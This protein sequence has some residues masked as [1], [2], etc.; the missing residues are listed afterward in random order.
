MLRSYF[1]T[2][3][4]NLGKSKAYSFINVLGLSIGIASS[5]LMFFHIKDEMS[6]DH[7]FPKSDRIYRLTNQGLSEGDRHWAVVSP[8]HG[9]EIQADIPEITLTT[10]LFY[11]D[12]NVLAF[13]QPESSP[14]RFEEQGGFYSDPA[15][16]EM[17]DLEFLKGDPAEALSEVN[18]MILTESMAQRY[19][20]DKDPIGQT[21]LNESRNQPYRITGVV[22]DFDFNTH[23]KFDYLVS[24][25]TFY[26]MMISSGNQLWLEARGWAHFFTYCLLGENQTL[27]QAEAKMPDFMTHFYGGQGSTPEEIL[28]RSRLNLQ[29]ITDIHL[30]SHLEQEMG[31]NSDIAYVYIFSAIAVFLLVIA[32]VNFINIAT[33]LAFQR[34]KEVGMRKVMGA[35]RGQL[36]RQFLGEAF[37]LTGISAVLALLFFQLA[38]PVY[39]NLAGR[40]LDFA[41]ITQPANLAIFLA[42]ILS[43]SLA[44]GV[45]PAL[46]MAG[47][48]PSTSL[49][50]QHDPRSSIHLVRKGLVVFQFVISIFLI[51]STI[52]IYRQVSFFQTKDL[53]FNKD[54]LIA[55][56]L[57]GALRVNAV[58]RTETL[59]TELMGHSSISHV[60][61]ASN[62]PGERL[63]VENLRPQGTTEDQQLPSVRYLRVDEDF[64]ET[65]NMTLLQGRT[66][67]DMTRSSSA[68]I[69][70]EAAV[71]AFNLEEPVGTTATNLRG[72]T[73]EIIGVVKDFN[74]ASLHHTVEPLVLDFRPTWGGWLMIRVQG[75]R[76][77]EVIKF[78]QA[79]LGAVAPENLFLYSFV[80]DEL[81]RLYAGEMRMSDV[82]KVFSLLAVFISCLG[83]FGLSAYSAE[84]R[85]KEIGMRKVLGAS[86]SQV[87]ALLSRDFFLW[88]LAANLIAW[89][90]AYFAMLDWL[91]NFAYRTPISPLTFVLSSGLALLVALLTVSLQAAKAAS[92]DPVNSL[93]HE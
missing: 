78:L 32:A 29:P 26:R 45:Y 21:I 18:T 59:K 22:A 37:I 92:T 12:V 39:N 81:T 3:V 52:T 61:L 27:K 31:P 24:M 54:S 80:D 19:F 28:S 25:R 66:F 86:V 20:R 40:Q 58:S 49:R 5:L 7:K 48:Q 35:R 1:R 33:A 83:L 77:P 70:N 64:I 71:A 72:V 15:T 14:V 16:I 90:L 69:L 34:M 9:L 13:S 56:K 76:M 43:L 57:Y 84:L 53:G 23:L 93:R 85:T 89:P 63:S 87:V 50:S 88:V 2:A 79:K 38:L 47:F 68:F 82:F 17:F 10:R 67:K 46:F 73:G 6:W 62:L 74:F 4:R 91:K 42:I 65:M 55:V 75:G 44:A 60:A 36:I 30:H 8:L 11:M 41:L 51:F